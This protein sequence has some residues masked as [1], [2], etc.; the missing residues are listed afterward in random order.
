MLVFCLFCGWILLDL[1][2]PFSFHFVANVTVCGLSYCF[3]LG[4][5]KASVDAG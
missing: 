4:F 5:F 2:L 1:G 3:F